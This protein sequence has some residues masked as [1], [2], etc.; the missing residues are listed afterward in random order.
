MEHV[1]EDPVFR[2]LV[3]FTP[4]Q[5]DDAPFGGLGTAYVTWEA[6]EAAARTVG[7]VGPAEPGLVMSLSDT[8]NMAIESLVD[9]LCAERQRML[10]Q[11]TL[12]R[13]PC[14]A[15]AGRPVP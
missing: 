4:V 1:N 11:V 13:Q 7:Q 15:D 12:E 3:A 14:V 5:V 8:G 9:Q 2:E 10:V 6:Q